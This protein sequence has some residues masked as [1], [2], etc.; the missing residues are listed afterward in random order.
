[1]R[2]IS[3]KINFKGKDYTLVFNLNVMEEIQ[4]EY[5]TIDKWGALCEPK[6]GENSKVVEPDI[7]ALKYGFC[8]MLNE[9]IDIDNEKNGT[10]DPPLTL[11][12]VGRMIT[13]FGAQDAMEAL[14][15]TVIESSKKLSKNESSTKSQ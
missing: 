11:K 2:D 8:A 14:N 12:Q 4:N 13:E 9:G 3:T 6:K 1:M 5:G 15:K 10:S 7:K